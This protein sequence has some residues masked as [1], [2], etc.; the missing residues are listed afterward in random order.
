MPLSEARAVASVSTNGC[1]TQGQPDPGIHLS[2]NHFR[3]VSHVIPPD[4]WNGAFFSQAAHD[5]LAAHD[6]AAT[7]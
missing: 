3:G 4:S 2:S 5:H 6:Y 1:A 7:S